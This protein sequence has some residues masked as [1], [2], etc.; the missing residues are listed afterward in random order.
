[1][2]PLLAIAAAL[3]AMLVGSASASAI[4]FG[5]PD[6]NR[7]PNVGVIGAFIDGEKDWV[8]SGT[9]IAPRVFVTAAHC[10]DYLTRVAGVARGDVFVSFDPTFGAD[11]RIYPG[12][13][14]QHPGY[15]GPSARAHDVAV[16]V[17]DTAITGI[18]PARLPEARLL[19]RLAA[20]HVLHDRT[21]TA[22]GYG[23]TRHTKCCGWAGILPAEAGVR[24]FVL[25]HALSLSE[26]WLLLSMN[27]A[28]GNGGTCYGDSGGPHFLGGPNSNLLVS[29]TV[30]GDAVCR[31]TDKTYRLDAP[32]ARRFLARFIG[33][34]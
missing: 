1:M 26:N 20:R 16:V 5:Q 30:T 27:P 13:A 14:Y 22:V 4:T 8:C 32:D 9:L 12:T 19:D 6:G 3:A 23:A 17:L 28:T 33:L 25:Q 15:P 31:A 21:F 11:S 18:T 7:H 34:P 10:T 29:I 24:R 2:R